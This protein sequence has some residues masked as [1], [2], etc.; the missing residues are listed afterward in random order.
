MVLLSAC[1]WFPFSFTPVHDGSI[2]KGHGFVNIMA[3]AIFVHCLTA[4]G[5]T[6]IIIDNHEP[7]RRHPG[8]EM[9]QNVPG[10]GVQVRIDPQDGEPFDGRGGQG[11]GK[12]AFKKNDLIVQ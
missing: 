4:R 11:L 6:S 1:R 8:I 9:L 5:N 3:G 10:R 12:P 2:D 7:S